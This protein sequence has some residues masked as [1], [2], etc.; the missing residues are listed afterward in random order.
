MKLTTQDF[1]AIDTETRW[2]ELSE[3]DINQTIFETKHYSN[4]FARNNAQLNRISLSKVLEWIQENLEPEGKI[5]YFPSEQE[6]SQLW[7]FI[8]GTAIDIDGTRLI[9]IPSEN[10]DT[11]EFSVPQEWVDIPDF[12]GDC[13][14]AVQVDLDEKYL[15]IW[16]FTSHKTL[17]EKGDYDS[18]YRNYS[19]EKDD[20]ITDLEVLWIAKEMNCQ[21]KVSV[22]SLPH[23]F[24]TVV[25]DLIKELG[26]TS[27]YSPRLEIP[28]EEWGALLADPSSTHRLY[29]ERVNYP[30]V[31]AV[32]TVASP[33]SS[34]ADTVQG[35]V[36][37][38]VNNLS[39]WLDGKF[40]QGWQVIDEL[41][42]PNA[43]GLATRSFRR[44]KLINLETSVNSTHIV[45]M[46]SLTEESDG[47]IVCFV[48]L[49]PSKTENYLPPGLSFTIICQ[50]KCLFDPV[51]AREH[52]RDIY[53]ESPDI[54]F[55]KK[56]R[57][58]VQITFNDLCVTEDFIC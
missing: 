43:P 16:G 12:A 34:I 54:H 27:L 20:M 38:T 40:D 47:K 56:T 3:Q 17:K 53:I 32:T 11:E 28:F 49:Y 15:R 35:K 18:M 14:L 52:P 58:Q 39:K 5:K 13:Y 21:E 6:Y 46:I 23:L 29:E 42:S 57:F 22:S 7:E 37:K 48:Q 1:Q 19:L 50:S 30:G 10:Y 25:D 41:I 8:N 55:P 51:I 33:V 4:N 9:I 44:G 36:Q 26:E 31:A 24:P 45:L 2:F